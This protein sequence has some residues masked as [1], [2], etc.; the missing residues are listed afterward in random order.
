MIGSVGRTLDVG[1][2]VF[3]QLNP[4]VTQLSLRG[5]LVSLIKGF[6]G[7]LEDLRPEKIFVVYFGGARYPISRETEVIGLRQM[8]ELLQSI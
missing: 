8:A 2:K 5:Q 3:T 4:G 1:S 6:H 7:T